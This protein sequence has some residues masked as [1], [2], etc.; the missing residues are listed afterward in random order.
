MRLSGTGLIRIEPSLPLSALQRVL[1]TPN[2]QIITAEPKH[3]AVL[4][5]NQEIPD[6]KTSVYGQT[7]D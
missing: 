7:L 2:R 5:L 6:E 4:L 3:T 1:Y